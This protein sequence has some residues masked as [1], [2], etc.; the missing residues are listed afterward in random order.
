[1]TA[2]RAIF[3]KTFITSPRSAFSDLDRSA[4][5][6]NW[7]L[8]S[9]RISSFFIPRGQAVCPLTCPRGDS[10]AG[11][12]W[13][14]NPGEE[15]ISGQTEIVL[16]LE[17][18]ERHAGHVA[19]FFKAVRRALVARAEASRRRSGAVVGLLPGDRVMGAERWHA[20]HVARAGCVG[21]IDGRNQVWN[22][23]VRLVLRRF[24]QIR[25][26]RTG[27]A[28]IDDRADGRPYPI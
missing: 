15:L 9:R 16:I 10:W 24:N 21:A 25:D 20:V 6:T 11:K 7:R 19:A 18:D 8:A 27:E 23:H 26:R 4:E 2:T 5:I 12:F 28:L 13:L 17:V 14:F 3:P 1:M 22:V